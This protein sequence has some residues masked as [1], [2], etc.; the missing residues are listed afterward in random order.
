MKKQREHFSFKA[1]ISSFKNAFNGIVDFFQTEH[2]ALI[3]LVAAMA[4]IGFGFWLSISS[5]EWILIIFMIG[6]VFMAEL[7][8]T[9]IE[10]LGDLI[11]REKNET[12][13]KAKD[14]S[15]AAVLIA[16]LT[17]ALIGLIIF[18]PH[19]IE[20]LGLNF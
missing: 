17:S 8:N 12:I 18:I 13:K 19:L 7:F 9:A 14:L 5:I 2:N 10:K 20:K 3:H 1:R 11:T 6:L 16:S 4:A 15:A